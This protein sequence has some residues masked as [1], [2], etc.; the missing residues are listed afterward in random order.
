MT[1][2]RDKKGGF[3]AEFLFFFEKHLT[4]REKSV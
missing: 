3:L 1:G 4:N 2:I